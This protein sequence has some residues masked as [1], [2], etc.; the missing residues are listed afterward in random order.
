MRLRR[1]A[2]STRWQAFGYQVAGEVLGD[3]GDIDVWLDAS[4]GQHRAGDLLAYFNARASAARW[5]GDAEA[6]R[7]W[8]A[9]VERTTTLAVDDTASFLLARAGY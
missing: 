1:P 6:E 5:R 2:L 9:R 4:I 8:L 3:A 7:A